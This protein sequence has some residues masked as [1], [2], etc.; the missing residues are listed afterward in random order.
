M[1]WL[2]ISGAM[3]MLGV[4]LALSGCGGQPVTGAAGP[5][6]PTAAPP[7][8]SPG[9]P[10]PGA[11]SPGSSSTVPGSGRSTAAVVQLGAGFAP[12]SV[13]LRI[14]Q[15]F[16]VIVSDRVTATGVAGPGACPAAAVRSVARGLLTAQC[17][18]GGRYLF[19]AERSG[20][21]TVT[22]VV[23]PK[24]PAKSV[25]PLWIA[26]PALQVTIA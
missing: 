25:C 4:A 7:T 8:S 9:T 18:A 10:S 15:Q 1:S 2:R 21:A 5:G 12:S 24:C 17:M 19:T 6:T 3:A 22:A 16:L 11:P 13:R 20:T 26:E 14:G 23:K